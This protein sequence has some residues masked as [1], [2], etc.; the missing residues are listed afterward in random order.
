MK[1]G[2]LKYEKIWGREITKELDFE[3]AYIDALAF[4][5]PDYINGVSLFYKKKVQKSS[6]VKN[7]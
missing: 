6:H 3:R 2:T 7:R 4:R 5:D 1:K